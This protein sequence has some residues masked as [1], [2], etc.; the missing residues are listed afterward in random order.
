MRSICVMG[1]GYVGL[2]TGACLSDFGNAV[3]CVDID[4]GRI[5]RLRAGEVPLYEPGLEEMM[6]RNISRG[7]LTF[8]TEIPFAIKASQ[9]IFIAVGTPSL[10]DGD[11]DMSYVFEAARAIGR[12]MEDYKII[13]NKSTVPVGTGVQVAELIRQ[14]QPGVDFDI[15]S[16][17]EFLREG[18]AIDDFMHPDRLV[19]GAGNQRSLEAVV[20]VYRPLYQNDIPMVLTDVESAEMIKYAANALLAAKISFIN[21][22]ANIC[23]AYGADVTAVARGMGLDQRIGP[24]N[25]GAGAGYGGSCFPKDVAGLAAIARRGQVDSP[26]IQAINPSNNHQRRRMIIK[27]RELVGPFAGRTICLLGLSFKPDTDDLR[28]APALEMIETLLAEGAAVRAYDPA[29]M[30]QAQRLYP[31]LSCCDS[32]YRAAEGADALV[33]MTEWN[34]FRNIDLAV[35]RG[36]LK[37]PRILDCRNLYHPRQMQEL[38][39]DYL[40]I[41]RPPRRPGQEAPEK[42]SDWLLGGY[43]LR[44]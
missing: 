11:V 25:L 21:E 1:T 42:T 18:S 4:E 23:E 35:L 10:P 38:G 16:N 2:V 34:E 43:I 17:P 19:I 5:A 29:A 26:L 37:A 32:P 3:T 24:R 39:F 9:L 31:D 33:L 27:L 20:D 14:T 7:R 13:V 44:R 8:S 22:I 41:G 30:K 40:S 6:A 36:A 12:Y 28:E 15:V